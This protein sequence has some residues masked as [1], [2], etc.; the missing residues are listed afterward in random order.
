MDNNRNT[1]SKYL[2]WP[3]V[4]RDLQKEGYSIVDIA[5]EVG[6]SSA[7]VSALTRYYRRTPSFWTGW[8]LLKLHQSVCGKKPYLDFLDNLH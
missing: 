3:K 8:S 4:I 5:D 2:L 6:C 1:E 7:N